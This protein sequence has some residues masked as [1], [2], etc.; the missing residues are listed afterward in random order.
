MRLSTDESRPRHSC[1]PS[2][3][4]LFES[5]AANFGAGALGV[6]LTGMG[7]DGLAGAR[8]IYESGGTVLAQD[9]QTSVVWGMPGLVARAGIASAVVPLPNMGREIWRHMQRG[10]L[11]LVRQPG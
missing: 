3:D 1:R 2:V 5:V 4:V 9:E 8:K 10:R 6:V 7:Q 11:R